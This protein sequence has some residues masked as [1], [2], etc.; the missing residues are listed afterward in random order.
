MPLSSLY[1]ELSRPKLH[2]TYSMMDTLPKSRSMTLE[3]LHTNMSTTMSTILP[4]MPPNMP[5]N[6]VNMPPNMLSDYPLEHDGLFNY[7]SME[8]DDQLPGPGG[9][10]DGME[11]VCANNTELCQYRMLP[12]DNPLE[13][14]Y[15]W[16]VSVCNYS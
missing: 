5:S 15:P 13:L 6:M 7:S 14:Y 8:L 10:L 1:N 16:E 2:S 4:S 3:I 12:M 11:C 9:G